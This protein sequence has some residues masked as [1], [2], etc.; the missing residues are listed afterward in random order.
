LNRHTG[1]LAQSGWKPAE[2]VARIRQK[3]WSLLSVLGGE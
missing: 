3:Y 2:S 1:R